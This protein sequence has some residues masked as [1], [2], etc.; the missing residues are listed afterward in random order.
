ML[1]QR[2]EMNLQEILEGRNHP[3]RGVGTLQ[4][5]IGSAIHSLAEIE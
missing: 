2:K 1:G 4:P 5:D 3:S